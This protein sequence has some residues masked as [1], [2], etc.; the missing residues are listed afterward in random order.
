MNQEKIFF[1]T[2]SACDIPAEDEKRLPNLAILPTRSP[3]TARDTTRGRA[4]P[5]RNFMT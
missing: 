2:D 3:R 1:I 5:R 4:L